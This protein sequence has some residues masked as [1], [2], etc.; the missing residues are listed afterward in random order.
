MPASTYE[1]LATVTLDSAQRVINFTNI[2]QNYTDLVL[3]VSL[4]A[5]TGQ[6]PILLMLLNNDSSALYSR[7]YLAGDGTS[8]TSAR[9]TGFSQVYPGPGSVVGISDGANTFST[10]VINL[11]DYSNSTTFKT[12]LSRDAVPPNSTGGIG[13]T[14]AYV[15]LWRNTQPIT[16]IAINTNNG[17]NY[18]AGSTF[19]LYGV[20]AKQLKAT[21]GDI[22]QT[23][24]TYWYHAFTS[25]GTFTPTAGTLSCD[26]LVIAGGG[27][28]TNGNWGGGS[29]A[30][31]LRSI[32]GVSVSSATTVTVGAGGTPL[33]NGSDSTFTTITSSGGGYGG[34]NGGLANAGGSGGGAS[35]Y[36][37]AGTGA[38][39]SP[40]TSPAQGNSGGRS[41]YNGGNGG[42]G[43][44]GAGVG[45][46][47]TPNEAG[48]NGGV[49][50]A[51]FSS[52]ATIT[53]TGLDGYYAGGGG[54]A[55]G[56]AGDT[57]GVGFP[58]IGGL[59]G[60]GTGANGGF[61]GGDGARNT[62]GGAGGT[63]GGGAGATGGSGIVIVR[64]AV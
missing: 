24:G 35:G 25:S 51:T 41:G 34:Q 38:A 12:I 58:G 14:H 37:S 22:I 3:V 1:P 60:G 21:G 39:S 64:Y 32:T 29:G 6:Y 9:Q 10:G 28:G 19:S 45:S 52:W 18:E 27:G 31:G 50:S 26:A 17:N 15:N 57:G 16:S 62:G 5:N 30:G 59:G 2:P 8:A 33:T 13:A 53:N 20:G 61:K 11:M 40:T 43:A 47:A 36:A 46:P 63:W 54:G 44:G 4:R 56:G 23:D 49:G 55:G 48:G 7:T 42:G